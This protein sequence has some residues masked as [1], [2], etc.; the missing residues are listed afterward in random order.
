[1]IK[2]I[3]NINSNMQN[4]KK[5]NLEDGINL[6]KKNQKKTFIESIDIA[7]NL[8]INPKKS[9][10][11]IRGSTILPHG[12]GRE[13]KVAVFTQGDN[14]KLAKKYGAN[15][16]GGEELIQTFKKDD[17]NFDIILA[18]PDI[19][20]SVGKLGP[21]LGPKGLMPNP[22][23]GTITENI[24]KAVKNAKKGQIQYKNDKNG[25][26]HSTIGKINFSN[27]KIKENLINLLQSLEKLK[28]IKLKGTFIKQVVLSTTMGI[29]IPIEISTINEIIEK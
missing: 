23:L 2:N 8:G 7:I 28:P 20:K 6:L 16:A 22:K 9:D 24:T 3:K 14:I 29:G 18:S 25:I 15:L 17:I 13:I 12:I 27:K 19:M 5:Y 26:I 1:M 21:M 10:Q 11:N 4:K